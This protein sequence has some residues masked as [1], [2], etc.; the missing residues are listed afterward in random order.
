MLFGS[1]A[2][3][4]DVGR[5]GRICNCQPTNLFGNLFFI[6]L[7][8]SITINSDVPLTH[9]SKLQPSYIVEVLSENSFHMVQLSVYSR[10]HRMAELLVI[11]NV[12]QL[13]INLL[14]G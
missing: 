11:I 14:A 12:L 13:K 1:T 8:Y 2:I 3:K 9:I 10:R 4:D 7:V 5:M 6:N